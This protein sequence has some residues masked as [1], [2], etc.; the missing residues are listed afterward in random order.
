MIH[1]NFRFLLRRLG[2]QKLNT[3][4]HILGLT[5]GLSVCILIG[6]FIQ[7]E[8]SF[9]QYHAQA[10]RIYRVNQVWE[11]SGERTVY[12][13]APAPLAA[14]LKAEIPGI[15]EVGAVY[16]LSE[17]IVEIDPH[18]RFKQA[19]ILMV[20]ASILNILDFQVL[21]GDGYR[22]LRQPNQALLTESTA[23]KFFGRESPIGKTFL[24]D[25]ESTVTVAGIIADPPRNTHLPAE[26]LLSYFP[27]SPWLVRN[28]N[29]W[30]MSF[31]ASVYVTLEAGVDPQTLHAP[32]RAM[33]DRNINDDNDD[34]E[35]AY[36]ELQSLRRIHLEPEISGGGKWV[37]AMNP[38]WLWFF[39]GISLM[40]L[41]LACINFINLSTAQALTRAREVGIRKAIGAGRGQLIV[42][43]LNEA[44]LLIGISSLL[45]LAI[46]RIS[47]PIVNELTERQIS[48][49]IL[50]SAAGLGAFALFFLLTG[51]LTGLYP[52]WL[53]AR[54]KPAVAMK[55]SFSRSDRR[56]D[57]L[58]KGLVVTQFTI[59]ATLLIGLLIMSRQMDYFHQKN[60]GFDQEN[61]ITVR[62]PDVKKNELFRKQLAGIPQ[63]EDLSF[64]M[65]APASDNS[66]TTLMH[67]T[68][69]QAKDRK[70]V[71]II[72][73]DERYDDIYDLQ[74][75][76]GRMTEN[77]DTNTVSEQLPEGTQSLKVLV[78]E[79]L[80][81]TMGYASPE[82][83]LHQRFLIGMNGWEVD[84]V[85]VI[86]D[87]N[88]SS[89]HEA[90]EPLIISPLEKFQNEA[91][92]KLRPGE[93]L[94]ATL[95]AIESAW[96]GLFPDEMY[97]F[98]FL[99]QTIEQ[100]YESESR[101]YGLFKIFAGLAMLISCLGLWGLA[102]FAA[103]QRT[104]EIGIR[105]VCGADVTSLIALLSR[106][107]LKLVLIALLLAIPLAWY[108]M[109]SWLQ[110]FSF[111]ISIGWTV[112][113]VSGILVIAIAFFTV[114]FQSLKA[115]L[116]SPIRALRSE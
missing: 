102:T 56:S 91:S 89:L 58:R 72:W 113:L 14:G 79:R 48:M 76:A 50:F 6:L 31:G 41:L 15:E 63:I 2:K 73:A 99:E 26:V 1:N 107:F 101:L 10:D 38:K 112:F 95:A 109:D 59:S 23:A 78:N 94:P 40:V 33:Y 54:F 82:E 12:Y 108:G 98:A 64:A 45:A 88:I 105:K 5:L 25:N 84:V 66:W 11:E 100:Y 20:D 34:P 96:A 110:N 9:D 104:K 103:V 37:K 62:M 47:L 87:F 42:Q 28:Q 92:I 53:I 65:A 81:R 21:A 16:P 35:V 74:L 60:L 69:L 116:A 71:R 36:A 57:Y 70:Q 13:D 55:A 18:K 8:L 86:A 7:H 111:R 24:L 22:D 27:T 46:T 67:E 68:D 39:G 77:K 44:F 51:L 75:L 30:G 90:I 52:A 85:G 19:H 93:E 3:G 32:I 106:D 4:L 115:A 43:F 49:E 83:A 97:D 80:I 17:K 114:G 29:N 61:I